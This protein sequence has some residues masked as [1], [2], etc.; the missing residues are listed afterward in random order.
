M[1]RVAGAFK[2]SQ[3]EIMKCNHKYFVQTIMSRDNA[4]YRDCK[5]SDV[6]DANLFNQ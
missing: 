3:Y 1:Y 2:E 4:P 6:V 5:K